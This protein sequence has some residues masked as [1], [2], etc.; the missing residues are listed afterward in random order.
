MSFEAIKTALCGEAVLCAPNFALPFSVQTDASDRG[1]GTVLTQQV[2]GTDRL[3][4]Y[5]SRKLSDREGRYS[6]VESVSPSDGRSAPSATTCWV[7]SSPST[8]T[9]PP[10]R[11]STG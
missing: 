11:G 10:S 5:L 9:T 2:G 8:P 6:T 4:L 1:L 7:A 3:V